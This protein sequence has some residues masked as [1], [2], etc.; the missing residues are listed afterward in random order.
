M[1]HCYHHPDL[2]PGMEGQ[3]IE[4]IDFEAR[5]AAVARLRVGE[6]VMLTSGVGTLAETSVLETGKRATALLVESTTAVTASSPRVTLVQALAKGDRSDIAV[7]AAT[8]LGVDEI[9]PWQ[10]DRSIVQ[11]RGEKAEKGVVKWQ[12]AATEAAK[13]AIRAWIPDVRALAAV[14]DIARLDAQLIVL[15]PRAEHRL[16][17]VVEQRDLAF[18]VGP[19]GGISPEELETLE[20]AGA[21]RVRLG[22]EVLRTSTAGLAGIAAVS[23]ILGRW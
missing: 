8:E 6:R 3:R 11:W 17:E 15:D 5:H 22:P 7:A 4:L 1:A 14:S 16:T 12:Q 20:D 21:Q 13:Q 2:I 10:A 23:P 9:V 19:E 18:I